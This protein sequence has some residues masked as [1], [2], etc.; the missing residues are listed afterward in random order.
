MAKY[1]PLPSGFRELGQSDW[2]K[3]TTLA[4][5]KKI[6][7]NANA[8]GDSKY[9][10]ESRTMRAGWANEPR[11]GA[12]AAET[13]RDWRDSRDAVLVRVLAQMRVRGRR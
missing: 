1:T 9:E 11:A 7:G 10:A 2:A 8:V 3:D 6:A 4:V 5:A 12:V 13:Q